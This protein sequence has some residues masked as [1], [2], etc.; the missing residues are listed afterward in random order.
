MGK[1]LFRGNNGEIEDLVG[2]KPHEIIS[3]GLVRTFQNIELIRELS[4]ID[5]LL[6]G[7]HIE[8]EASIFSQILKLPKAREEEV[9]LRKK[10]R[11]SA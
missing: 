2:Q 9:K 1:V 11:R 5:N 10:R 3:K 8:F 7:S 6:V 4:V